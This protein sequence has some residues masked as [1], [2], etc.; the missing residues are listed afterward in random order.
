MPT[1]TFQALNWVDEDK[2]SAEDSIDGKYVIWGYGRMIDGSTVSV[3]VEK[4]KPYFY[5]KKPQNNAEIIEDI[6]KLLKNMIVNPEEIQKCKGID[7]WGYKGD[8]QETFYRLDFPTKKA[9]NVAQRFITNKH[10]KYKELLYETSNHIEPLLRFFHCQDIEPAQWIRLSGV[11]HK[12]KQKTRCD[13][14]FCVDYTGVKPASLKTSSLAPFKVMS[15]DLECTST[16]GD[17]PQSIKSFYKQAYNL[18]DTYVWLNKNVSAEEIQSRMEKALKDYFW[19]ITF[20]KNP[21]SEKHINSKLS[22]LTDDLIRIYSGQLDYRNSLRDR[23]AYILKNIDSEKELTQDDEEPEATEGGPKVLAEAEGLED[24]ETENS[25]DIS[26]FIQKASKCITYK[27]PEDRKKYLQSINMGHKAKLVENTLKENITRNEKIKTFDDYIQKTFPNI[28]ILGDPIIQI[29]ATF[30]SLGDEHVYKKILVSYGG[31]DDIPGVDVRV[32]SNETEVIQEFAEIV[33]NEDPDI[34]TGH[35]IFGFD[36]K[37]I[38]ERAK[39]LGILEDLCSTGRRKDTIGEFNACNLSSSALGDNT[40]YYISMEG[41][42]MFDL[43]KTSRDTMKLDSFKL[44]NIAWNNFIGS[45]EE[46]QKDTTWV[47]LY[48]N[49][50][51]LGIGDYISCYDEDTK[52]KIEEKAE[53]CWFQLD[54]QIPSDATSWGL[55]KDDVGPNEIFQASPLFSSDD[56]HRAK[57]GK[58]CIKD[59]EL[60][61]QLTMKISVIPNNMGMANVC[62]VPLEYLFWR[63]MGIRISS[64]V[65]YN[66]R[67]M[68]YFIPQ[69]DKSHIDSEKYEGAFV[70]DPKPGIYTTPIAVGDFSSLYPSCMIS[71]NISHDTYVARPDKLHSDQGVITVNI[72]KNKPIHFLDPNSKGGRMGILPQTLRRLLD[73]RKVLKKTPYHKTVKTYNGTIYE[74]SV[75]EKESEKIQ[76]KNESTGETNIVSNDSII[77]IK[78]TYDKFQKS[79]LKGLEGAYKVVCNSLYGQIGSKFSDFYWKELAS[80]TT[81]S[82][83]QL[84]KNSF[85]F[86]KKEYNLETRYCDTDSCFLESV[87]EY[88]GSGSPKHNVVEKMMEYANEACNDFTKRACKEPHKLELEKVYY[89]L[90]IPS[91]KKYQ[92]ILYEEP[93]VGKPKSNGLVSARRD[94]CKLLKRLFN[95]MM[96]KIMHDLHISN[97]IQYIRNEL[98]TIIQ[99][100]ITIEDFIITKTLKGFYANPEQQNHRVL[101]DKIAERNPG[102]EYNK[103]ERIP[104]VIVNPEN[105]KGKLV[106]KTE[107]PEFVK[108]NNN[109]AIDY[110]YYIKNVLANPICQILALRP[111]EIDGYQTYIH[112]HG[113]PKTQSEVENI[114]KK[115]IFQ[116]YIDALLPENSYKKNTKKQQKKITDIYK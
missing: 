47:K 58:Y 26:E 113:E 43:M 100:N 27:N 62:L 12:E 60:C 18:Y 67:K 13:Y 56:T 102:S 94:N 111:Y 10:K 77:D 36:N 44:D 17:F 38:G 11:Q 96:E 15:F 51:A 86:M 49:T 7:F 40:M 34:L 20:H 110:H 32:A 3:Q 28:E 101:N 65:S 103:N 105:P 50:D 81:A 16:H 109:V 93:S 92:G 87:D 35:N 59:C 39:Q 42:I 78:D 74:G 30:H 24:N 70:L 23:V 2:L 116:D 106:H 29:G 5:I 90:I 91:K 14:K 22:R 84:I 76:V 46:R 6:R 54:H 33:R 104:F 53:A 72:D 88:T 95:T 64:V 25:N 83:R 63:G 114:V 45:I 41:R 80:C 98:D 89:P 115:L 48:G 19:D 31:C 69:K 85:E 99:G 82:G 1:Y 37:Y 4:F 61:N 66:T 108:E 8:R 57:V 9:K 112:E 97:A 68:G 107:H 71:E 79:V 75:I 73:A 55:V 21:Y 52:H